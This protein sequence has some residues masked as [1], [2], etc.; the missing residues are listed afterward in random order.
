MSSEQMI[1]D[2]NDWDEECPYCFKELA[3]CVCDY[4]QILSDEMDQDQRELREGRRR[5][6]G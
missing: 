6:D 2:H 5:Y 1:D 4:E 3:D